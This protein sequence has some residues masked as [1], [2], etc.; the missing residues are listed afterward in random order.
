MI[1]R[2]VTIECIK[3]DNGWLIK[4]MNAPLG[5]V[6]TAN[7]VDAMYELRAS[8]EEIMAKIESIDNK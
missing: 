4:E 8:L 6:L 2:N 3:T 7:F 1:E 5:N